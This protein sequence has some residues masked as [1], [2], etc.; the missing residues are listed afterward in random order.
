M[1]LKILLNYFCV[2]SL[3]FI[4]SGIAAQYSNYRAPLSDVKGFSEISFGIGANTFL[5]DLGGNKGNGA[6]FVK[7]FNIKTV[8]PALGLSYAYYLNNYFKVAATVLAT[9]INGA[10]S[11]VDNQVNGRYLRNLS[12]NSNI[13]ELSAG[14]EFYPLTYFSQEHEVKRFNPFIGAGIGVIAYY[15]PRTKLNGKWVD[16]QPLK[17]EGQGFAE[18]PDQKKSASAPAFIPF[19]IGAKYA[20][21][22]RISLSMSAIF[23]KTF[24]DDLD[25]V[26]GVYV[27]PSL[28][29][30][31]LS[32]DDAAKAEKLYNRAKN[33]SI[34]AEGSARGSSK[35]DSYTTVMLNLHWLLVSHRD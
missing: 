25:N 1:S 8:K 30:R 23:R 6:P 11:L 24:T 4:T 35:K 29:S 12:F 3:S 9:N 16:L 33:P 17:L 28:F 15:N 21:N 20:I 14:F 27:D 26:S 19:S 31:Y 32:A 18:Y 2:L 5:G 34:F 7:D 13:L 10:D 22:D